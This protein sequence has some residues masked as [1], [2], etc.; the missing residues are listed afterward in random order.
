MRDRVADRLLITA[1]HV[2]R[3]RGDRVLAVT[4]EVEELLQRGG[5]AARSAPHDRAGR[6][7][8]NGGEVPLAAA[9]ADL[10]NTDLNEMLE[11]V[12]IEAVG[13]D[14]GD[15][16]TDHPPADPEQPGDRCLGHLLRQPRHQVLEVASVPSAGTGPRDRFG[17]HP[18]VRAPHPA[19]LALDEAPAGAEIEMAPALGP[20]AV[21]VS[22]ELAAATADPPASPQPD[23]HDHPHAAE[24]DIRHGRPGKAQQAVECGGDAH[25]VLLSQAAGLQAPRSLTRRTAARHHVLLNPA[26]PEIQPK[27]LLTS[28]SAWRTGSC[29][30]PAAAP[31]C[32]RR[33]PKRATRR[34]RPDRGARWRD[35]TRSHCRPRARG[36]PS[37]RALAPRLRGAPNP[38]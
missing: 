27:P 24:L 7:V 37:P 1:G 32:C 36:S 5:V 12:L 13:N 6:V 29:S 18:A 31:A 19:Q 21:H 4:N 8:H 2:D 16:L 11:T 3:H 28:G 25:V 20:G 26:R 35:P 33:R 34:H 9:V 14:A 30:A 22:G 23:G 38:P 17:T 10:V 15:D